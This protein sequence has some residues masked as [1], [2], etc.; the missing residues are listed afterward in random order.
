MV[1][2]LH[3]HLDILHKIVIG[4]EL[5]ITYDIQTGKQTDIQTSDRQTDAQTDRRTECGHWTANNGLETAL[6]EN[7]EEI[8]CTADKYFSSVESSTIRLINSRNTMEKW[9]PRMNCQISK[10]YQILVTNASFNL[11]GVLFLP[12]PWSYQSFVLQTIYLNN[13]GNCP[14]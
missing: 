8:R 3:N 4:I 12:Q 11:M 1:E 9:Y 2:V 14:R 5:L 6:C 13:Y 7:A 10:R